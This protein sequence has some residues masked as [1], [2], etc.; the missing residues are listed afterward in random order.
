MLCPIKSTFSIMQVCCGLW[1]AKVMKRPLPPKRCVTTQS[2]QWRTFQI[3]L[4]II[5]FKP[6]RQPR[7]FYLHL[8]VSLWRPTQLHNYHTTYQYNTTEIFT[9]SSSNPLFRSRNCLWKA[10][11]RD[12]QNRG[13]RAKFRGR[14]KSTHYKKNCYDCISQYLIKIKLLIQYIN[15]CD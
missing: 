3:Y 14:Y 1:L 13:W 15:I 9:Q 4:F 8:H 6:W 7:L 2:K 10:A 11:L 12:D 5:L